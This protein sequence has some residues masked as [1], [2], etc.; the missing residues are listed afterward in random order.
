MKVLLLVKEDSEEIYGEF[1]VGLH[2]QIGS[3]DFRRLGEREQGN[4]K[5]YFRHHVDVSR[6]DRILFD[7][8]FLAIVSQV[9][10]FRQ[11]ENLVFFDCT[12]CFDNLKSSLH[13]QQHTKFYKKLPWARVISSSY[14]AMDRLQMQDID[15]WCVPEGYNASKYFDKE[16]KRDIAMALVDNK[17]TESPNERTAFIDA[18]TMRYPNL[19]VEDNIAS[20]SVS[21]LNR[22]RIAV[23]ADIGAGEYSGK[24]F[25]AMA[26]GCLVMCYN[27]GR[28]ESLHMGLLDMENIVL[29]NDFDD[30]DDKLDHLKKH[31]DSI[32]KIA[33]EG[34]EFAVAHHRQMDLGRQAAKYIA[35]PMREMSNYRLGFSAFGLRF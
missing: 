16:D 14:Q 6:Y 10:F 7:L 25:G 2:K 4:L 15:A 13:Y 35:A 12:A 30:F 32:I 29:F 33:K 34:R 9:R 17:Y 20:G 19:L 24:V 21:R 8:D 3:V 11:L 28:D 27:Q 26:S 18:L 5:S 23:C 31:P 1:Y 22:V